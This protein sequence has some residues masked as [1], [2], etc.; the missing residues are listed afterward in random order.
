M[1]PPSPQLSTPTP[2][3]HPSNPPPSQ[4]R[5]RE[6]GRPEEFLGAA[7]PCGEQGPGSKARGSPGLTVDSATDCRSFQRSR[8][9]H[10]PGFTEVLR[11]G[12]PSP[13]RHPSPQ[14]GLQAGGGQEASGQQVG[15][16]AGLASRVRGGRNGLPANTRLRVGFG[17]KRTVVEG[18]GVFGSSAPIPAPVG[19]G[20]G[21]AG[22]GTLGVY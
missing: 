7:P 6:A 19:T 1:G 17:K 12:Q 20:W 3:G 21:T 15:G 18:G 5:E 4:D 2:L 9:T 11:A 10:G 22:R 8:R 14:L 13:T 16:H